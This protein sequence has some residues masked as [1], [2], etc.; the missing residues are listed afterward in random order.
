M[1]KIILLVAFLFGSH[2]AKAQTEPTF[3][4]TFVPPTPCEVQ[5]SN[6]TPN[7]KGRAIFEIDLSRKDVI[8]SVQL[9]QK[10]ATGEGRLLFYIGGK[11]LLFNFTPETQ[12]PVIE[13]NAGT[14][15]LFL[16]MLDG[17][18]ADALVIFTK[19]FG[20]YTTTSAWAKKVFWFFETGNPARL[21]TAQ[22]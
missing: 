2:L 19:Q 16:R 4:A 10:V 22:N 18:P 1:K 6:F 11:I 17:N 13:N 21:D 12:G 9:I 5:I 7:I 14:Q 15:T 8:D 3:K 20:A